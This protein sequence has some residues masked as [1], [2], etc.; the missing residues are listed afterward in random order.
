M[1]TR[2]TA[3]RIGL[4]YV[5]SQ[6]RVAPQCQTSQTCTAMHSTHF[7]NAS[8]DPAFAGAIAIM[9]VVKKVDA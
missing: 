2:F 9:A 1:F 5:A 8:F 7:G 4:V 3:W 6:E